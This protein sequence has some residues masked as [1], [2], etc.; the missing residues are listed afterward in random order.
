[1]ACCTRSSMVE[2]SASRAV[3]WDSIRKASSMIDC[4]VYV[5]SP[6]SSQLQS[7][8]SSPFNFAIT[9]FWVKVRCVVR[10]LERA[11]AFGRNFAWSSGFL[12]SSSDPG[13]SPVSAQRPP[14]RM[15]QRQ[16]ARMISEP[17]VLSQGHA[18]DFCP[19]SSSQSSRS[20]GIVQRRSPLS[21]GTV[22]A[23][24]TNP[25]KTDSSRQVSLL[26]VCLQPCYLCLAHP[27]TP[28]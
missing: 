23:H 28:V 25:R 6:L 12:S 20:A 16:T 10:R 1:M 21:F 18:Q 26:R 19:R 27:P 24:S 15:H 5:P 17:E 22:C 14:L 13:P 4:V 8:H 11:S 3:I 2:R 9:I 7:V